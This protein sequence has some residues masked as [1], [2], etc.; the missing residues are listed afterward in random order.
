MIYNNLNQD[1]QN[2]LIYNYESSTKFFII[3]ALMFI[4][5]LYLFYIKKQQTKTDSLF[6]ALYRVLLNLICNMYM[7][8]FPLMYIFYLYPAYTFSNLVVWTLILYGII[9]ILFTIYIIWNI[10]VILPIQ[11]VSVGLINQ[12]KF[13]NILMEKFKFK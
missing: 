3:I 2:I 6:I 8:T 13:K 1:L 11:L 5:T 4:C 9:I 10:A 12:E 7:Y